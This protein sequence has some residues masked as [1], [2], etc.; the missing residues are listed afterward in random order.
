MDNK[1]WKG[2]KLAKNGPMITHLFFADDLVLFTEASLEKI[3]VVKDC[4]ERLCA[5]SGQ[6][7]SLNKS[8]L[9]ISDN[10]DVSCAGYLAQC[11]GIPLTKD[12]GRYLGVPSIHGRVLKAIFSSG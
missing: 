8:K 5:S 7:V 11:R 10:V 1:R 9:Y 12:L 2:I 6:K 3:I 4:L